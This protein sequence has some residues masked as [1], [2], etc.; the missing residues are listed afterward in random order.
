MDSTEEVTAPSF[1]ER[2]KNRIFGVVSALFSLLGMAYFC[3]AMLMGNYYA[4][5]DK[6]N[7]S[8]QYSLFQGA[9]WPYHVFINPEWKKDWDVKTHNL[10]VILI[11]VSGGGDSLKTK[12]VLTEAVPS[13]KD[14]I[15][16]LPEEERAKLAKSSEA[17]C[18]AN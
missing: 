7:S 1:W 8:Y 15:D 14:W 13:L 16:T 3:S 12:L 9:I 4:C 5:T 11:V 2:L 17:L 18:Q 10:G 6:E